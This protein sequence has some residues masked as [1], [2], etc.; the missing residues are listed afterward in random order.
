MIRTEA[1]VIVTLFIKTIICFSSHRAK[2]LEVTNENN[3]NMNVKMIPG[4]F[5]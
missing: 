1:Q 5:S 3:N 4:L 2:D